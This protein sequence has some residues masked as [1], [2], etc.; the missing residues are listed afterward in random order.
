MTDDET[1]ELVRLLQAHTP[2]HQL[3]SMEARTVF[4]FMKQRGY[5]IERRDAETTRYSD[6]LTV[7]C[8]PKL[9]ALIAQAAKR[10]GM[11]PS[12]WVRQAAGTVL[13]LDGFDPASEPAEAVA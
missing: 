7:R 5:S 6:V 8:P 10:R 4:Q 13:Q 11:T 12:E 3:S 2:L 1:N 9:N